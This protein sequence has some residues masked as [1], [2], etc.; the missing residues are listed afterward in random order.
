MTWYAAHLIEYF[1]FQTHEQ[2]NF[3]VWESIILVNTVDATSAYDIALN[4]GQKRY[5]NDDSI[6]HVDDHA[7]DK[8]FLGI[9]TIIECDIDEITGLPSSGTEITYIKMQVKTEDDLQ[10]LMR[11]EEVVI[12]LE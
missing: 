11:G 1:K 5:G 10:K 3:P 7:A 2:T 9:R 4:I 8:V 12:T 6:W